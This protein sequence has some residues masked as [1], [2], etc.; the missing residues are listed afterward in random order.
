MDFWIIFITGF[1]CVIGVGVAVW[2]LIDIRPE[3][4]QKD[5]QKD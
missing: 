3:F 5:K 2:S 1:I 4:K